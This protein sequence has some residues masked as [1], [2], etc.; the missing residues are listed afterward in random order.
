MVN[1]AIFFGLRIG[2]VLGMLTDALNFA[3]KKFD[4]KQQVIYKR[5]HGES[6]TRFMVHAPKTKNG[7]RFMYFYDQEIEAC[8]KNQIE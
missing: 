3:T 1:I 2:E 4:L 5:L 6:K 7:K 8:L